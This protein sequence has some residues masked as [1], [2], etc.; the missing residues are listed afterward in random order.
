MSKLSVE[1][2]QKALEK[3]RFS[4]KEAERIL[5]ERSIELQKKIKN[6]LR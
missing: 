4:R 3:E 5:K 2:L 1:I 6:L